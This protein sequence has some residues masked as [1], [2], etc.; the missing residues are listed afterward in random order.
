M[1]ARGAARI[2]PS[3][4]TTSVTPVAQPLRAVP[5]R[6]RGRPR[7]TLPPPRPSRPVRATFS[8]P[9]AVILV[10]VG[11]FATGAGLGRSAGLTWP[12][13]LGGN[14]EPPR[15]FPVLAPSRPVRISIPSI[16]V[17]A[18]VHRVGLAR[19]GSIAVPPLERHD[20]TGWYDEGPSP[21]QFGPA[22]IVGHADTRTGPSVF[23]DLRKLRSGARVE[24]TRQ[25]RS[26]AVFE[27]NSVEHFDKSR[28]PAERVYGDYSRPALRLI[29]CGGQWLGGSIGYSDNVIAFASLVDARDS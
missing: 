11:V 20:E 29:T 13:W 27:V 8:G 7:P 26:V 18:P 10:L 22:I 16:K 17:Q 24:V 19:D 12:G 5:R 25:D 28:L 15:E 2:G 3:G 1:S 14:R 4:G 9:V 6:K 21:G 23:H